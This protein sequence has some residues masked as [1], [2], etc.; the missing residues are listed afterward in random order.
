MS[1]EGARNIRQIYY[2]GSLNFC[3]YTCSYCPFSK[4]K[5]SERIWERDREEWFR[6]VEAMGR[7]L[8]ER[9]V[10]V[11][12]YG[13]ALIHSYYWEGLAALGRQPGMKAVG[14]QS[15]FSFP[16]VKMLEAY[17]KA[18]GDKEKLR[19]WG[20]F[21]PEMTTVNEFLNQCRQ[22]NDAGVSFCVGTVGVPE[23]LRYIRQLREGLDAS[24][25]MWI[26]KMDGMGRGYTEEEKEAF[27]EL[28]SYFDLELQVFPAD[29]S[30]C[31]DSVL[32]QGDGSIRP[33]VRSHAKM[34]NLYTKGFGGLL[35]KKCTANA[36]DC[37]L[38]Y[39][40]RTDIDV[41]THFQPEPAFRI[42]EVFNL[43]CDE[44]ENRDEGIFS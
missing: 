17:E 10:L 5:Q 7:E 9:S 30:L 41:L 3:N 27:R 12:P 16:A 21:H 38:S 44:R 42:P 28:D 13:E 31:N 2:R 34:G 39:N 37:Y 24:V 29:A 18:G 8:F 6:F 14:A 33:C 43:R 4:K 25:Y 1:W 26:N 40:N 36:C 15:N 11:V 20:T 35:S 32:I 22:L 23:N 19:L